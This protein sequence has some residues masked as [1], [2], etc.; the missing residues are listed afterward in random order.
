M[1]NSPN[2]KKRIQTDF[3]IFTTIESSKKTKY[4]LDST[5][6]ARDKLKQ[7]KKPWNN[8]AKRLR[9]TTIVIAK[10]EE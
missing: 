4:C 5:Y 7:E 2:K 8:S 10:F 3:V 6:L 9:A 1:I